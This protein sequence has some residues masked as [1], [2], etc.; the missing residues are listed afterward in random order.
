MLLDQVRDAIAAAPTTRILDDVARTFW[1]AVATGHIT[2]DD[3]QPVS[4]ALEARRQALRPQPLAGRSRPPRDPKIGNCCRSQRSPD[5][6]RSIER[7]RRL[8]SAGPLPPTIACAFTTGELA[9]L[10]VVGDEVR[11]VR[12]CTKSVAEIAAR[13]GVCRTTVQNAVR[14]AAQLG[15]LTITERRLTG[16][17]N[18]TNLLRVTSPEWRTWLRLGGRAGGRVQESRQHGQDSNLARRPPHPW[19]SKNGFGKGEGGSGRSRRLE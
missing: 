19:A 7:R 16:W 2:E 11:R 3:A 17:R 13:A 5:R 8:A 14:R 1:R 4:E 6:A 10:K 12:C 9:V 15:L 18:D